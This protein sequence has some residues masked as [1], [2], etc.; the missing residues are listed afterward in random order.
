M[1]KKWIQKRFLV[2]IFNQK[3]VTLPSTGLSNLAQSLLDNE[4]THNLEHLLKKVNDLFCL[5]T[6]PK[7]EG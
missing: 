6:H 5:D 1:K 7:W 4:S 2:A 3:F